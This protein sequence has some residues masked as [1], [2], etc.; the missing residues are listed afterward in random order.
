MKL[1]ARKAATAPGADAFQIHQVVDTFQANMV[2][3]VSPKNFFR[4]CTF[5]SSQS[6]GIQATKISGVRG[7][8]GEAANS[9]R[10]LPSANPKFVKR[11]KGR[12]LVKIVDSR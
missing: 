5:V 1:L 9:K 3:Y 12:V 10:P 7:E 4:L 6:R 11:F 8:T 2:T